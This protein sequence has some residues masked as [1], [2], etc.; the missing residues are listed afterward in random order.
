MP[1]GIIK[2]FNNSKGFGFIKQ[3]NSDQ[4]IFV[5]VSELRDQVKENDKVEFEVQRGKRGMNAVDV[6]KVK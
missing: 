1:T 3:D 6:K 4:E 2:F 5:H